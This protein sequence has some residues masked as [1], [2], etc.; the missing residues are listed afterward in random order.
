MEP[1]L[2]IILRLGA[3]T[4]HESPSTALASVLL[5]GLLSW[6]SLLLPL[7]TR[8]NF[9]KPMIWPEFR[10]HSI[11]FATR[12]VVTTL[13]T[14]LNLWPTNEHVNA[15]A[16]AAVILGTVTIA[17]LITNKYGSRD[18]RTTNSMP[19]PINVTPEEQLAIKKTYTSAQ[20]GATVT[21]LMTDASMNFAPLLGIQMAPLLM[22]L[23]RKGKVSTRTYHQVYALSLSLGYVVIFTRLL[24]GLESLGVTYTFRA[25]LLF[26][27]PFKKSRRF[28]SAQ[29]FWTVTIGVFMIG[30]P[31]LLED[32]VVEQYINA[33]VVR[34]LI[35]M[36][37]VR[38]M[39]LQ[40]MTY[41]PLFRTNRVKKVDTEDETKSVPERSS[42]E[43]S[44][45]PS[46]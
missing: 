1:H 12:H 44:L 18:K 10:F 39:G 22:T 24:L 5:H 7:P 2:E 8:R 28:V 25:L 15:M 29:T 23:V 32:G 38:T 34:K 9:S 16:R 20:F 30:Y 40:A 42:S 4:C 31:L 11:L 43:V 37:L 13:V 3:K 17:S 27:L 41:A 33:D 35:W 19:Y 46:D 45:A 21:S 26:G 6:S 36:A 14:L